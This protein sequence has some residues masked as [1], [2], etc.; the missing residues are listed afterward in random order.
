[1]KFLEKFGIVRI[2]KNAYMWNAYGV[3]RLSALQWRT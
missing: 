3:R 1:M 2:V